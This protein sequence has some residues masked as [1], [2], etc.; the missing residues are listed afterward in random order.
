[1]ETIELTMSTSQG[2]WKLL[3]QNWVRPKLAPVTR[4]AGQTA[5]MRRQ[6]HWAAINQKGTKSEKSGNCLPTVALS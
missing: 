4:Q 2:P 3:T 1:M 6:P 5:S